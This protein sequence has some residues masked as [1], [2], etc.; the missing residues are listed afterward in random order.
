MQS[1]GG[2]SFGGGVG[3]GSAFAGADL[4]CLNI[5]DQLMLKL[6]CGVS[7]DFQVRIPREYCV[8][9]LVCSCIPVRR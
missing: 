2:K 4:T 6:R 1:G 8:E 7:V 3:V 9:G 5:V